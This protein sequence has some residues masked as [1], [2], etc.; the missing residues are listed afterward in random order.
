MGILNTIQG[1]RIYLDVNIWIYALEQHPTYS[2]MLT[3]LFQQVDQRTLTI[4]TS[5]L[6]LAEALVKPMREQDV[7]RQNTYR[8]FLSSRANLRVI[9]VQRAILIEAARLRAANSSL[10]LPD[11][12]HAAT[13][14]IL[15]CTTLLTNDQKFKSLSSLPIVILSE[16]ST[17]CP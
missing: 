12:I 15:N 14:V 13:A 3:E 16:I 7:T 2:Q 8:Q 17:Q 1:S 4:V 5:E 9:P 11:A 6:S 10:K